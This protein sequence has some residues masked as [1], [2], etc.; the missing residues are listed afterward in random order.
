MGW[1]GTIFVGAVVGWWGARGG[2]SRQAPWLVALACALAAIMIKMLGNIVGLF[3]D[4]SVVEWLCSVGAAGVMLGVMQ[5]LPTGRIR[6][7]RGNA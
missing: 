2:R 1:F 7:K 3:D 4:G 6:N 5:W